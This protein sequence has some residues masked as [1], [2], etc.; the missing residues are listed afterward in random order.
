[1][2]IEVPDSARTAR[3]AAEADLAADDSALGAASRWATGLLTAA[4]VASD[5][6]MAG[7]LV[8]AFLGKHPRGFS[9]TLEEWRTK[10][11]F[12]VEAYRPVAHK[13]W[14]DLAGPTGERYTL[15]VTIDSTGLVRVVHLQP[16][17]VIPEVRSWAELEDRLRIP[18]VDYSVLAARLEPGRTVILHETA[19]DRPM[20]TGSSYKLYVMRALVH[21]IESGELSWDD[22]VTV[23]PELRSLPTGDMQEL[24]DGTRVTVRET[25]YK[26]IAMSDNT[27]ADLIAD[28]LGREAVERAVAVSGHHD[29]SLLRP[30]LTSREVFELGWGPAELRKAWTERDEAGR[31]ELLRQIARPLTVDISDLGETVHHLGLDWHMSAYDVLEVL[32]ALA[33][34]SARDASGI[35]EGILAAYPGVPIDHER[36]PRALFKGG[37]C[38]GVMMFCWLLEDRAGVPHVLVLQQAAAEQKL[39]GDGQLLRGFGARVIESDLLDGP[40]ARR[41]ETD[42]EPA[43]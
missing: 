14:V 26:M 31:R 7:R 41:A 12:T 13:S 30:F 33:E 23:R 29:P 5:E 8:P 35:V 3:T 1:M 6:S 25:A 15:A 27:A 2:M 34:D 22:E 10:G 11:P 20:P 28:R 40:E 36:W 32:R 21:A 4:D 9:A 19:A 42:P 38:P 37:S 24:P 18:G 16:E 43:P 17:I 39:I